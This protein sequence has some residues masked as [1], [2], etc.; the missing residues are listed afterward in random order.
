MSAVL[1]DPAGWWAASATQGNVMLQQAWAA[2]GEGLGPE[3]LADGS[4]L[5]ISLMHPAPGVEALLITLPPPQAPT[6]CH[7]VALVRAGGQP[8]RYF[9][10]ER[11]IEG[12]GGAPRAYWAEWRQAPGGI[13]RIRGAD[14]PAIHPE[15]FVAAVSAEFSAAPPPGP[16]AGPWPG[17]Q[18]APFPGG[19]ARTPPKSNRIALFVGGGCLTLFL[20]V[21][22]IGGYLLY[23]EEGRGLHVP[24]TE[25]A[26]T[27]VEPDEPFKIQFKWDGTGYAFNNIWL[28]VD[29]G[30]TSGGSFEVSGSVTCSRGSTKRPVTATLTGRGAH[31]VERKGGDGF[32]GWLYLTDEYERSS[33]RPIE[34]TGVIK[35]VKGQWTKGRIVVTQRQRPSDWFAM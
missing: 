32:S 15:A 28:V 18:G 31:D 19:P 20:F 6:E 35:P 26:S 5:S 13:M 11:G 8:P 27:P 10:A 24:D 22:S 2:A 16:Q 12:D 17:P 21:A 30:K 7:Y 23:Q 25:V 34:C 4:A 33:G 3:H 9:V 29:E 1:R 14:L